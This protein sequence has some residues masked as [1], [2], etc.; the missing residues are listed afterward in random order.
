MK[1]D[2]DKAESGFFFRDIHP[3]L[4]LGT[5]SDRYSGWIGQIYSEDRYKGRLQSRTKSLDGN[6]YNETVLPVDSVAEYYSHFPLLEIDFTF[7]RPLLNQDGTPSQ[8][9]HVLQSY[10]RYLNP[11]DKVI[12]KVPQGVFARK[13]R[14]GG[15]YDD[16]P[17]YLNTDY[18]IRRFYRPVTDIL[19]DNL[20]GFIFEQEYQRKDP[21]YGAGRFAGDLDLFFSGLPADGRYHVEIRTDRLIGKPVLD[22]LEKK[23]AGL[24]LSHWTW[25]PSLKDQYRKLSG[26]QMN[27]EG[28]QVIRLLTPRG[29]NYAQTYAEAFPFSRLVE[30]MM[31]PDMID[32]TVEIIRGEVRA[33]R[34]ILILVNNRA[35]GNA[36]QTARM[37]AD[38]VADVTRD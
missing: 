8:N 25:L 32:D 11:R 24:V 28:S 4:F 7:Y 5:T 33:G 15:A 19:G 17:D 1:Q 37:I 36:P 23:G 12:V 2:T 3:R 14:R 26:R 38:R 6:A 16:N 22:V 29:K 35:G 18:F 31:S 20:C 21:L 30:G 10:R 34:R 13:I 9:Y 27:K